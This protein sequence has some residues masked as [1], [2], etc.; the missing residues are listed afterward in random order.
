MN[1]QK[2]AK[3]LN[4]TSEKL[5]K[6]N[7]QFQNYFNPFLST[8]RIFVR[9][10]NLDIYFIVYDFTAIPDIGNIIVKFD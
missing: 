5:R 6:I 7:V 4:R 10:G 2:P 1:T 8:R 9:S 3:Q